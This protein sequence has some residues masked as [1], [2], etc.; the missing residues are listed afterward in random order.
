MYDCLKWRWWDMGRTKNKS[1]K[2]NES[3][4]WNYGM[5]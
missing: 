2:K 3:D 4:G 1:K 5:E